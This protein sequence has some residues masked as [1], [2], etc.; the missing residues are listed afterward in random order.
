MKKILFLTILILM[1]ILP[2]TAEGV[3]EISSRGDW[4][5]TILHTNDAHSHLDADY[6]GRYGAAKVGFMA[7]QIRAAYDNVLL[8]DAGDYVMGT[9]YYTVFEGPADRDVMNLL[10][11][12]AMTLG[13]HEFDKGNPGMLSF[14]K[15]L[16]TPV[17]NANIDFSEYPVIDA[18]VKPFIIKDV[19]GKKVG[20][21]GATLPETPTISSPAEKVVFKDVV[22]SVQPVINSLENQGVDKIILLSHNGY[23]NEQNIDSGLDVVDVIVV[24][25]EPVP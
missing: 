16:E 24:P 8:L 5:L 13:N 17:V 15:G 20:I 23:M 11:Y 10:D 7:D 3:Q 21:I 4:A 22:Q 6:K 9:V 18:L 1:L 19:S 12:D 14:M 2:L 25:V